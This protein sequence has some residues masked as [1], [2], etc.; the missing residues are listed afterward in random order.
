MDLIQVLDQ[1]KDEAIMRTFNDVAK[2][3]E[4][5][6]REFGCVFLSDSVVVTIITH[7]HTHTIRYPRIRKIGDADKG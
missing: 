1:R 7:A 5:V 6:F 2:H 4:N 3:F